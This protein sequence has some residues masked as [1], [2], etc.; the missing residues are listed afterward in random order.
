VEQVGEIKMRRKVSVKT[1]TRKLADGRTLRIRRHDRS[2]QL[3]RPRRGIGAPE[4]ASS[5]STKIASRAIRKSLFAQELELQA[6]TDRQAIKEL[7][8]RKKF[9]ADAKVR[10]LIQDAAP[11]WAVGAG[12]TKQLNADLST[13]G[14][15]IARRAV[16]HMNNDGRT[17]LMARDII[18]ANE[19]IQLQRRTSP[20]YGKTFDPNEALEHGS[21][22]EVRA[23][24]K[25]K[26]LY[27]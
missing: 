4:V 24:K 16:V 6:H 11:N 20:L 22:A 25:I 7:E 17:R 27:K 15:Q 2:I 5:V 10:R 9:F 23:A 26:K 19:E 1:H 8:H 12:A 14:E 18:R 3:A 13:E 21:A